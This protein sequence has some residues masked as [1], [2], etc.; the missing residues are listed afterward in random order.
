MT[1]AYDSG[2]RVSNNSWGSA[3]ATGYDTEAQTFDALVR[4]AG[5]SAGN[6]P[7]VIV[8]VAGNG[9]PTNRTI[10]SPGTAK[11][12]ITV[13]SR[14]KPPVLRRRCRQHD[15]FQQSRPLSRRADEA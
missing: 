5:A 11:N 13:G 15:G 6:R 12:V 7:M 2:A 8:F 4:D 14:R 1:Q 10:E 9:G 3:D